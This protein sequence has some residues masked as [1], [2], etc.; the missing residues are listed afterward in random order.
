MIPRFARCVFGVLTLAL[1]MCSAAVAQTVLLDE[2]HTLSLGTV[3]VEHEL[4]ITQDGSYHLELTDLKV[5]S[6]LVSAK[7][8]ITQGTTVI[9]TISTTAAVPSAALDFT[10]T[11][12]AYVIR[13]VGTTATSGSG[14]VGVAVTRTGETTAFDEFVAPIAAPPP[15]IPDN[16]AILED[17]FTPATTGS[18]EVVLTDFALPQALPDLML[19][20]TEVGGAQVALLP[21]AGTATFSAQAG[22]DYDVVTL[23][24]SPTTVNAGLFS[25][26]VRAAGSS[27]NL[28]SRTVS[29]GRVE[30]IAT[31]TLAAG[32]HVL[33]LNDL[34][35]PAMLS[36]LGAVLTRNDAMVASATT[37]GDTPFTATAG[38]HRIYT[39]AKAASPSTGSYG[40][41]VRPT[42]GVA[43][44][45]TVKI[46]G[47]S[48]GPTPAYK[49][50]LDIP[51]AGAYRVR[52]ADFAFPDAFSAMQ[53]G[54]SQN[55]SL[56]G[57]LSAAGTLE[58]PNVEA[59][60]LFLAV[61]AQPS[62]TAG[63]VFGIDVAASG[64]GATLYETTQ[65]VE[66]LFQSRKVTAP[67]TTAYRVTLTDVKFPTALSDFGAIVTRGADT[68]GKVYNG[69]QFDFDA[70][71]GNY[72]VSFV[73][74]PNATE[75]A[76]TY[77]I[78]VADKPPNP[79]VDLTV[80]P[81]QVTSGGAVD[82]SWDTKN[83]TACLASNGWTG[84]RP[85]SGNEHISS[86]S[87]TMTF[88]L[89][90]TGSG[91]TSSATATVNVVAQNGSR[92]GGGG[93]L[94][95]WVLLALALA[96][97]MHLGTCARHWPGRRRP[98]N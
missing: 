65:G 86:V 35:F 7:L 51:T 55:G 91:G 13:I 71:A 49:F 57:T 74:T 58:L 53:L 26:R 68:I 36:E 9:G 95:R 87:T 43:L 19:S 82:L 39:V 2:V 52:L 50:D 17:T 20:V 38:E 59:G 47:D 96:M 78:H 66:N 27:T 69:G 21:A 1:T 56:L 77:G 79:T 70:S 18:Y 5:P 31:V 62:G 80:T 46:V 41:E 92:K 28:L 98:G 16:R 67:D 34:Q 72:F 63:G 84:S 93:A 24:E 42:G 23:A 45:S 76:G 83:A 64:G 37:S 29:I 10:A 60:K 75:Q 90:C 97:A 8:A 33:S 94:D 12:G 44:F 88:K 30:Q 22:V 14:S 54:A 15:A 81:T 85:V 61:L 89:E 6:A 73:A 3:A 48:Q 4:D 11:S 25:L 32:S 40:L